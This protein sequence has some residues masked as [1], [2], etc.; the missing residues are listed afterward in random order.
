MAFCFGGCA[1]DGGDEGGGAS[2]DGT[3]ADSAGDD[4]QADDGGG[5][6]QVDGD[7]TDE[8]GG[9]GT[10]EGGGDGTSEGGSDG[11][12]TSDGGETG[13]DSSGDTGR[14]VECGPVTCEAGDV[15]VAPCCGG[16][17]PACEP[18]NPD[19]TCAAGSVPVDPAECGLGCE[20]DNCCMP[21]PCTPPPSYC[22]PPATL[23]CD[24]NDNCS[25]AECFGML[26]GDV[27]SCQCA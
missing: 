1:D 5:S 7:G 2:A 23:R 22:T 27:L 8:G 10:S 4:D 20:A 11:A 12:G 13:G 16:P 17:A 15:C 25:V 18:A 24:D 6:G 26:E 9:D 21:G 3:A 14:P 19:G